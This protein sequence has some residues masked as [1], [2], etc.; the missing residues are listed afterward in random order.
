MSVVKK[1]SG[2]IKPETQRANSK[3][4]MYFQQIVGLMQSNRLADLSCT[5]FTFQPPTHQQSTPSIGA[6]IGE[7][8]KDLVALW[9]MLP[10]LE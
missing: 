5:L 8:P 7:Y 1:V 4:V 10:A 3:S 9:R 2:I 6:G